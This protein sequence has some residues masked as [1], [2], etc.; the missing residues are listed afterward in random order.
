MWI[1]PLFNDYRKTHLPH[2]VLEWHSHS[3]RGLKN[4]NAV[5]SGLSNCY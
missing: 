2:S 1:L 4:A 5:Q 3:I